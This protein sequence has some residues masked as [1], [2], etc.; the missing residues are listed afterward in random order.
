MLQALDL[1]SYRL[2]AWISSFAN[3]RLDHLR[4][5]EEKGLHIGAFG[6]IE[7]LMPKEFAD[8]VSSKNQVRQG[9]YIHAPSHAHAAA[10]AVLRNGYLT[11]SDESD[12]KD[13]LKINL[14]SERTKKALDI[15]NGIQRIPLSELLGYR[16]ERRL[17]DADLDYLIDEFRNFFPLNKDDPLELR[18]GNDQ[19]TGAKERIEP[20]NLT[21]GL[22]VHNNWKRLVDSIN[23]PHNID[24]IKDF[25]VGDIQSN[26]WKPFYDKVKLKYAPTDQKI[27]EI[28]GSLKPHL[29]YLLDEI[30]G[31]SDLCM[32]ESVY[33][34]INGNY[35][36]SGAVLDGMSGDGQIPNPE[37]STTPRSGPQQL[38]RIILALGV[39]PLENLTL[40]NIDENVS[41]LN[42]RKIAEPNFAQLCDSYLGNVIFWLDVKDEN[43]NIV[44]TE[45]VGLKALSLE[46]LDLL[47][48]QNS[49]LEMRLK[50]YGKKRGYNKFDIRYEKSSSLEGEILETKSFSDLH[51]LIKSLQ[52]TV[53]QG[54]ALRYSNFLS[55]EETIKE[56]ILID[57]VK[58]VFQRYYEVLVLYIRT[59]KYLESV[60]DDSETEEAIENKNKALMQA[61][62]FGIEHAIPIDNNGNIITSKGELKSKITMTIK[63]LKKRFPQHDSL[64]QTLSEWN[65]LY[66]TQ[67]EQVFLDSVCNQLSSEIGNKNKFNKVLDILIP[68]M[69]SILGNNSFL[70]LAPF[71]NPFTSA[72]DFDDRFQSS[73]TINR[74]VLK[75]IEQASYVR[76][77]LKL[78]DDIITYNEIFESA[79]FSFYYDETKFMKS[80]KDLSPEDLSIN[81]DQNL[82]S[83]IL[84]LS[85]NH[86]EIE[87]FP[88]GPSQKLAG[89]VIDEW[90]DKIVSKTQDTA[91]SFHYDGPSSE[92]PQTMLLAV[93]PHDS[94]IWNK[95]TVRIVIEDTLKLAKLRSI[96]YRSMKD[97]RQF[98]PLSTL[99]SHGGDIY[100]NLYKKGG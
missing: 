73:V 60:N 20:R 47:Y 63:E 77:R 53:S 46:A 15:I 59:S 3:Q 45:E 34:A 18:E 94:H 9:G 28:I 12:K 24:N 29:N 85:T 31:L 17:H 8:G 10:A 90:T 32:A 4:A 42:P 97:L 16:L 89:L 64:E 50:Y 81:P 2:D 98:L 55:P 39:T 75:W 27:K 25:M 92:A 61:S 38:Q 48:I 26:G 69:R 80:A 68:Q 33:Q 52:E 99:N 62:L 67:G 44:S 13:L 87:S 1:S 82:T 57:S 7:S 23:E 19:D 74:K 96:D 78:F 36:R 22:N 51:F 88:V 76:P 71:T 66:E 11:H 54:Q 93:S 21:D 84:V 37:I 91:I 5:N 14:N 65:S 72:S 95:K 83:T 70:V 6:W 58:E 79:N 49:E 40:R 43:D 100:I 56:E 86:G 30:D 35:S 41:E